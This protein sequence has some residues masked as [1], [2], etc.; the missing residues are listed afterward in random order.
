MTELILTAW[1]QTSDLE[2][3]SVAFGIAYIVLASRENPWCWPCAFIG[4]GTAAV[5]FWEGLLPMEAALNIYYLIIAVYGWW[6]WRNG[7]ANDGDRLSISVWNTKK[8]L[9]WVCSVAALT[10][11][12]G[13]LLSQSSNAAMP[14]LDSFTTWGAVITTWMVT[15]KILENWLYWLVINTASIILFIEREFYLYAALFVIYIVLSVYGYW[16]W[17]SEYRRLQPSA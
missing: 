6:C 2:R 17:R 11:L 3:V 1:Q 8:H 9:L 15:Q 13:Y 16:N 10:L 7:R 12:S 5:L 4:T 14:Y